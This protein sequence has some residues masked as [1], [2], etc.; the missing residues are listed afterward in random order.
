MSRLI[1]KTPE[2]GNPWPRRAVIAGLTLAGLAVGSEVVLPVLNI[3]NS[4]TAG[5][6]FCA[7]EAGSAVALGGVVGDAIITGF[8]RGL[9]PPE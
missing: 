3:A 2:G 8:F 1:P 5:I 7:M 6:G 4:T 9:E